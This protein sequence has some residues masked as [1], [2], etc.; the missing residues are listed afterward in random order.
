MRLELG[1]IHH[2]YQMAYYNYRN[3]ERWVSTSTF[4][5]YPYSITK[6]GV[7]ESWDDFAEFG[8]NT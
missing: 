1:V 4:G 6:S 5:R 8:M 3:C 2:G 7:A